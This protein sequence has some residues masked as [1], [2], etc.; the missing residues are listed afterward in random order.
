MRTAAIK[1]ARRPIQG[2]PFE[3]EMQGKRPS[4]A[5]AWS[6]G[7]AQA[8]AVSNPVRTWCHARP[9]E[10]QRQFEKAQTF[11]KKMSHAARDQG[12]AIKVETTKVPEGSV[13][14]EA[15]RSPSL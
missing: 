14:S 6:G 12:G 4:S 11:Q 5:I 7:L 13:G 2:A 8:P 9:R 15:E 3:F 10:S 1:N